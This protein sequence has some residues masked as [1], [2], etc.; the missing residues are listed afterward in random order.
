MSRPVK[1]LMMRDYQERLGDLEDAVVVRMRGIDS[2]TTNKIRR[3]LQGKEIRVTL[4]RNK[5]FL[6]AFEETK[7][8]ALAPVL[9]GQ[10]TVAY[11]AESV[12]H[13]AREFVELLKEHPEVELRGAVLDGTL[14]EG[15][16]GVKALSKFPTRDEAL[17]QTVTLIL[18]PARK[19][20]GAVKGPGGKVMGIVKSIE[21]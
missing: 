16:D 7:L 17:S 11:G 6:K 20:L 15:E 3:D 14:F 9:E 8:T 2:N 21:E 4:V 1:E 10:N 5:L 12:V 13:V 19:L 18:S